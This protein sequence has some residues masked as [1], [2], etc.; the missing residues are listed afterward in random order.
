ML[1]LRPFVRWISDTFAPLVHIGPGPADY[2]DRA[3]S[4]DVALYGAADMACILYSI[5]ALD[6]SGQAA[7]WLDTLSRFQDPRSGYLIS[8]DASLSK[9][10]NTAF[11]IGAMNLFNPDLPNGVLPPHRLQFATN[12]DTPEK[13]TR[14][15]SSLNWKT[16]VYESGENLI[17]LASAFA[18]VS[19]VV[20]AT[21]IPWFMDYV[22]QTMVDAS[23]GMLGQDKP[24]VGDLDQIGGTVHFEFF[25][26][27][28]KRHLPHVEKRVDAI[29]GLQQPDGL[30]DDNNPWWMT[31]DATYML[32]R[33]AAAKTAYRAADVRSA[34]RR[35]LTVVFERAMDPKQREADFY[36]PVLGVHNLT[37]A[38]S[39]FA[40]AQEFLGADVVGTD[41]PL[42]LVLNRRPY[43]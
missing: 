41:C 28:F 32:A 6:A 40:N 5:D 3:G 13:M 31:F 15:I 33:A 29:L 35:A 37:G 14:Y 8:S 18:N 20:P 21:W 36:Q 2:T 30:W 27:Y 7:A 25:W 23:S 38:I 39:L 19:G 1:D 17:G 24:P 43:I 42:R 26:A 4:T 10:H 34:V 11:A 9:V 12:F 22:D 16:D